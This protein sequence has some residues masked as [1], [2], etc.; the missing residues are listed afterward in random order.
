VRRVSKLS[1]KFN[2]I[3]LIPATIEDYPIVQNMARFYVYDMS[4]YL[5]DKEGW[6]MPEDGL[7]ECID[8]KK[9]FEINDTYSF[10]IR[11][12]NEL[13]GFVIIDKKGS[14]ESI[15]FNMAQFFI[16]R[17]FKGQ[18]IGQY[19]AQTCFNQFKGV[20]E[21][22]ILP[23]N[24]G[25][26][27]FWKRCIQDYAGNNFTEYTKNVIHLENCEKNIFKFKSK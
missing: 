17:K 25:A 22:M 6:E 1:N 26:Y 9:Y 23:G 11:K 3:K 12:G 20:W 21:V 13:A 18:S 4:E 15:D 16:L 2:D 24:I 19:V 27:Q 10:L 8:F 5:G 14:D 7:Y